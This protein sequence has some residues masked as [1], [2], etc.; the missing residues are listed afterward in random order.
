MAK[1][2]ASAKGSKKV[3]VRDLKVVKGGAV[4]GGVKANVKL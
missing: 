4:K 1:K 2:A 3:S